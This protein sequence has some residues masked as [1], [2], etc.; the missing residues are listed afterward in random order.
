MSD[1]NR[2]GNPG[3]VYL[4][5]R[6]I[7]DPGRSVRWIARDDLEGPRRALCFPSRRYRGDGGDRR[8]RID[9]G[10]PDTIA[11]VLDFR[12]WSRDGKREFFE[13][14][15]IMP[16]GTPAEWISP[17][18][19]GKPAKRVSRPGGGIGRA[20]FVVRQP[21]PLRGGRL[22]VCEGAIDALS[23]EAMGAARPEDGIIGMHGC[24][25]MR[26]AAPWCAGSADVL[27]YPHRLD[28]GDV[29]EKCADKLA[30]ALGG[31]G[32]VIRSGHTERHDLNDEL[33]GRAPRRSVGAAV[34]PFQLLWD[35]VAELAPDP[36]LPGLMW[37]NAHALLEAGPKWGKTTLLADVLASSYARGEWLGETCSSPGPILY[38][39]EMDPG[40]LRGW[41]E[42]HTPE[43][44]RP[45]IHA[46]KICKLS[47]LG[48][49][50]KAINPSGV[51]VDSFID[52]FQHD[53]GGRSSDEWKASHVRA[54]HSRLKAVAPASLMTQ[55]TRKSDGAGR[56][57]GDLH[58]AVDMI[59]TMKDGAG[60]VSYEQPAGDMREREL[61]YKGRWEEPTRRITLDPD[62][63]YTPAA[64][65]TPKQPLLAHMPDGTTRVVPGAHAWLMAHMPEDGTPI[66]RA[67]LVEC[68]G[69]S[70]RRLKPAL[71]ALVDAG[72]VVQSGAGKRGDGFLF[73]RAIPCVWKGGQETKSETFPPN[74]HAAGQDT[75]NVSKPRSLRRRRFAARNE[76]SVHGLSHVPGR[77]RRAAARG[78]FS[79]VGEQRT[80]LG[81][82]GPHGP[83]EAA[84][85]V[86]LSPLRASCHAFY[87]AISTCRRLT[88]NARH[89][90]SHSPRTFASPRRLKRRKP[91]TC[92]IQP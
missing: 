37:R 46:A 31:R 29:G 51:I 11:G 19:E 42:K 68:A 20:A 5:G 33:C 75:G 90:K 89:T 28:G 78:G 9:A 2:P 12:W 61:H 40:R 81:L 63:G 70:P 64:P 62:R 43:G 83:P 44:C 65:A 32:H 53:G 73:A 14:E 10:F 35:Y 6:G 92:L 49:A 52:A 50:V 41:I 26:D 88:F 58:A 18:P 24:Y 57:S 4:A 59:I 47:E 21:D 72:V 36:I 27:I 86:D 69:T 60:K 67:D 79:A 17:D 34:H 55:H 85:R 71:E 87:A 3:A 66:P 76:G 1:A 48:A 15:G 25:G 8:Q 7:P 39:S 45:P 84:I 54:W 74:V 13:L 82:R 23:L 91:S 22:H 30:D 77:L 38:M 16:D 56:D 80:K